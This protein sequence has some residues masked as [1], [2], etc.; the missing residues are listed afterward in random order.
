[1]DYIFAHSKCVAEA[2]CLNESYKAHNIKALVSPQEQAGLIVVR[3]RHKLPNESYALTSY[4]LEEKLEVNDVYFVS[5]T[6]CIEK[7]QG[8]SKRQLGYKNVDPNDARLALFDAMGVVSAKEHEG[9]GYVMEKRSCTVQRPS[10]AITL[11]NVF[12][13]RGEVVI[14]DLEKFTETYYNG[15]GNKKGFGFGMPFIKYVRILLD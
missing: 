15:Y 8:H 9:R 1:M 13:F 2:H 6:W 4:D 7:R 3:S 14:R 11:S 10:G 12:E 5:I